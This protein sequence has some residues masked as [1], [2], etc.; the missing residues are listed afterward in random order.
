MSEGDVER[1][2]RQTVP[3]GQEGLPYGT[4]RDLERDAAQGEDSEGGEARDRDTETYGQ[5]G[6]RAKGRWKWLQTVVER[7]VRGGA[8]EAR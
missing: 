8:E 1:Q 6:R 7:V 4:D 3:A 5:G 2:R